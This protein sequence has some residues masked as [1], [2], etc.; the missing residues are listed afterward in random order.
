MDQEPDFI[1]AVGR[2]LFVA[3]V[4][5]LPDPTADPAPVTLLQAPVVGVLD[6]EG[7]LCTV[8]EAGGPGERGI[9][10]IATDDPD[11]LVQ[12]WTWN[13]KYTFETVNGVEPKIEP[14]AFFLPSDAAVDLTTLVKVPSSPGLGLE[15]VEAAVLRA[16]EEA[17]KAQL[18]ANESAA[19]VAQ[20]FV[21]A[22]V[23]G[24]DL[25]LTRDNGETVVAGDVRGA[26][27]DPGPN[28]IPTMEAVAT[29]IGTEASV[30]RAA[31]ED[32]VDGRKVGTPNLYDDAVSTPKI[33]DGAVTPAKLGPELVTQFEGYEQDILARPTGPV[34]SALANAAADLSRSSTAVIT[35]GAYGGANYKLIRVV[36]AAGK[37]G[38]IGKRFGQDDISGTKGDGF[39]PPTETLTSV[40]QRTGADIV[41]HGAGWVVEPGN[42]R[43]GFMDGCQ[44]LDGVLYRDFNPSGNRGRDA[45]GIH[46]DGSIGLYSAAD[47]ATGQ[48]MVDA[49]VQH[50]FSFGPA[51]VKAGVSQAVDATTISARQVLAVTAAGDLLII[52]VTGLSLV[53][54]LTYKQSADLAVSLGAVFAIPLDGGGSAQ[55]LVQGNWLNPSSDPLSQRAAIDF[56]TIHAKIVGDTASTWHPLTPENGFT[57]SQAAVRQHNGKIEFRGSLTHATA[58][59]TAQASSLP[60]WAR[61]ETHQRIPATINL[62]AGQFYD[63]EVGGALKMNASVANG[64]PRYISFVNY[65][66]KPV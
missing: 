16:E 18:A 59:G 12:E 46:Y 61:P 26:Q 15:Q 4:P 37:P 30:A 45:I 39:T 17:A 29:A 21:A 42:P 27:G 55:A 19:L 57:S 44:I 36:G 63:F 2:I 50:S 8:N 14:H 7:Y 22:E 13:V 33:V 54:G 56:L 38:L 60:W 23:Q 47:G 3:S 53:S 28:T 58:T 20:T 6:H 52:E 1:A 35:T 34:V 5:Y 66:A 40:F 10:L 9:R 48:G 43:D 49:G 31:V 32:V 24:D 64:G 41:L 25:V 51:L 11:L 65:P 62:T